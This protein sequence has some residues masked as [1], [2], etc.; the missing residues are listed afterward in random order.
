MQALRINAICVFDDAIEFCGPAVHKHVPLLLATAMQCMADAG[1][2]TL[3]QCS[4]YGI[5]KIAEF[6]QD[7]IRPYLGKV[8]PALVA[9]ISAPGARGE[10]YDDECATENAISALGKVCAF[11]GQHV[12]L[13]ALLP[14]WLQCLPLTADCMEA[15][16]M[17]AQLLTYVEA[18]EPR[19]VSAATLKP[20]IRAIGGVLSGGDTGDM[21]DESEAQ[22]L[23]EDEIRPKFGAALQKLFGAF[24]Q[25]AM[26][27]AF[28]E[29]TPLQ[30][31]AVQVAV[32]VA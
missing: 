8:V 16:V 27:E 28:K 24:P 7:Q 32:A 18:G 1:N 6:A 26:D 29:L 21:E 31:S 22:E 5:S 30:Q 2:A 10:D 25:Q 9:V 23:V 12:D 15:K 13:D 19:I 14:M 20:L 17:H 11:H 3:R 4:V